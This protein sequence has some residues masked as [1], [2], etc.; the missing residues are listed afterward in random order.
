VTDLERDARVVFASLFLMLGLNIP[1]AIYGLGWRSAVWNTGLVLF[2]FGLY[3][4]RHRNSWVRPW[5][6]F[7]LAA[8][9][10][11]LASDWW[12][13]TRTRSLVYPADEPHLLVSPAY[14]PFAWALVLLQAGVIA[15]W[16][17]RHRGPWVA[18]LLTALLC[19]VNIPLY[20]HLAKDAGWWFYRDTPM[21]WNAPYYIILGEGLLGITLAPAAVLLW[22]NRRPTIAALLGLL[23]GVVI[24][25]AYRIA[26]W[27]LGPCEGA[28]FSLPCG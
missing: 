20:E 16:L 6:V 4:Y 18:A 7:G 27:L 15:Q 26:W 19:S 22:R 28:V 14:M 24:L 8:G 17:Y 12:L 21:L 13:V 2:L 9:F 23:Q 10:A 5:L 11:E 1:A 25:V 3:A